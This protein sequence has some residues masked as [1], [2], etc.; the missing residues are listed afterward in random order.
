[1]L[2]A[3]VVGQLSDGGR[4]VRQGHQP[5]PG[6]APWAA[7][8]KPSPEP[9]TRRQGKPLM[10]APADCAPSIVWMMGF[11]GILLRSLLQGGQPRRWRAISGGERADFPGP[12]RRS[13]ARQRRRH[14]VGAADLPA[15]PQ[16]LV[17]LDQAQCDFSLAEPARPA[18]GPGS[19]PVERPACNRSAAPLATEPGCP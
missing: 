9:A 16:T 17:D 10:V 7:P 5:H 2:G 12:A 4:G 19:V 1:M 11:C 8:Q 15:T 13:H 14:A 18:A 6:S 3:I